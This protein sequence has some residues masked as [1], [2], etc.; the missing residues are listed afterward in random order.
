MSTRKTGVLVMA[1]GT[2]RT[3]EEIPAYYTH[4]R[5]GHPPTPSQLE[6][7]VGRYRAIG[8]RS[9]LHDIT[10]RQ[11][12]GIGRALAAGGEGSFEVYLGLKHAA[13]FIEDAVDR[14]RADGVE[15]AVALVLAPHYARMSVGDYFA[16]VRSRLGQERP[17][18]RFVDSWYQEPAFVALMADR[19]KEA[20][21][22]FPVGARD[23][24]RVVFTAHSLPVEALKG[25]PYPEQLHHSGDLI[26]QAA[27]LGHWLFAWQSAGRT[28]AAWMGPDIRDVIK[29]LRREGHEHVLVCPVGFVSDHLE[30]LYDLDIDAQSLARDLDLHLRR[31]ASPNDDERFTALLADV[32]R[33]RLSEPS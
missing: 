8:G 17:R 20:L 16:R 30:V 6:E 28:D 12:D 9:P 24:V 15:D 22:A 19:V 7:L 23:E 27:G 11:A 14:M 5:H 1:Y 33:R 25:D 13:P 29:E 2:P 31:T 3:L 10:S 32:V 21:E 26:A 18:V 4:I